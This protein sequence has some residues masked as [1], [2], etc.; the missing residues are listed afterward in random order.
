MTPRFEHSV[1]TTYLG[2]CRELRPGIPF[3]IVVTDADQAD[4]VAEAARRLA[5]KGLRTSIAVAL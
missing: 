4:G 3:D 5:T 1:Q 2:I